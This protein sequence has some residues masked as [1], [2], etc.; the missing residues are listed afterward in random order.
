VTT[1]IVATSEGVSLRQ[2]I[3]GAGSR[4]VAGLLDGVLVGAGYLVLVLAVLIAMR[5]DGG[6]VSGFLIGAL[7]S[8][9]LLVVIAYHLLF[10]ALSHGQTPGKRAMGLRV[11]SA[12]G[13]PATLFQ[14]VVRALVWP[15]DVLL[16]VPLP[17]GLT[18]IAA[19]E[20]HQRLGDLAAN[21]LVVRLREARARPEPWPGEL[22]SRSGPQRIAIQ[23]GMLA[24]LSGEDLAFLR[25]LL[26][27]EDLSPEQRRELYVQ[28]ARDYSA[29]LGLGAFEDA[30]EV[31]KELYLFLREA[32]SAKQ[33]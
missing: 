26:T 2:E 32:L 30:R 24:R 20:R 7:S 27:R 9:S 1:L 29:R 3:A 16:P 23:P 6:S 15:I 8:G 25:E 19:T 12:D 11:M 28:A 22:Y 13:H 10:H 31:L 17:I 14:L 18:L 33:A 21:T 5:F 4:F